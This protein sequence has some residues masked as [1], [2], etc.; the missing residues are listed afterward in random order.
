MPEFLSTILRTTAQDLPKRKLE[1]PLEQLRQSVRQAP[2]HG[3]SLVGA[4]RAPGVSVIAEIKRASPSR[5]DINPDVDV[6]ATAAAY[7]RG[8]AAAVSVLTEERHFRGSLADLVTARAA[9]GLPILRKEFIIDE[10]QVWE[11]AE[12]GADAILLIVAALGPA[13]LDDLYRAASL[14]GLECLV[15]VHDRG[16]LDHAL[17]TGVA[18]IGI[19]NRDLKTFKVDLDTTINLIEFV[20]SGMPVVSESGIRDADDIRRLAAAGVAAV[21]VGETLMTSGDPEKALGRLLD[22][23]A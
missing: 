21:L 6:A 17:D 12:A 15:E 5:G 10:Y 19:N 18:L 9:C 13:G 8:G 7:E 3:R 16:E 22:G 11:A 2:R 14:A 1:R 20:P 4:V 23:A